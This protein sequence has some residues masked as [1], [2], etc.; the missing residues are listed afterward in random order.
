MPLSAEEGSPIK[1]T[2]AFTHLLP[3]FASVTGEDFPESAWIG[4]QNDNRQPDE[5]APIQ[6]AQY[7][8]L[9]LLGSFFSFA[10]GLNCFGEIDRLPG[11]GGYHQQIGSGYVVA[12]G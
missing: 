3:C 5:Y 6:V 9:S 8:R 4:A 1:R 12:P 2:R 11:G 10:K 7:R